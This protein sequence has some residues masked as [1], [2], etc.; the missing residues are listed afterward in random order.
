MVLTGDKLPDCA[1]IYAILELIIAVDD[2]LSVTLLG[3][4]RYATL[5]L[6]GPLNNL[7]PITQKLKAILG[8]LTKD[9]ALGKG[10]FR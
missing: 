10:I 2:L 9:V 7:L 3:N 4:V 6:F 1:P 5:L 8:P